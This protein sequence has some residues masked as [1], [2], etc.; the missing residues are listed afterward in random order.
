MDHDRTPGVVALSDTT[1]SSRRRL[2]GRL[3]ALPVAL[4]LSFF[5]GP[6]SADAKK[7]KKG[8]K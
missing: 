4:G 6:E 1:R 3:A 8:K 5:M 7:G 2:L